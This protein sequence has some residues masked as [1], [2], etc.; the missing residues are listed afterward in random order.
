MRRTFSLWPFAVVALLAVFAAG[1]DSV[2]G[3]LDENVTYVIESYQEVGEFIGNVR[4]SRTGAINEL[5]SAS[6]VAVSGAAVQIHLMSESGGIES[7]FSLIESPTDPGVYQ[8]SSNHRILPLRVYRLDVQLPESAGTMSTQ[9]L[10]PGDFEIVR[11]GLKEV[12]YQ[13]QPQFEIGVTRSIYP[14]RQTVFV[15]SVEGLDAHISTLTPFYNDVIE[16]DDDG[17][18]DE[19]D[20][21][22]IVQS[23]PIN[24]ENYDVEPDGTLTLALPWLAVAFYGPNRVSVSAIDDN[25]YD[26]LRSYGIQQGGSTLSPGEIPNAIDHV[27]GGIGVFGSFARVSSETNILER[28]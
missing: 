28:Q 2:E 17:D 1:C 14:T 25:L 12:T 4:L 26:F 9:T 6:D 27:D 16:P 11:E 24:E 15:F 20:D 7:S 21:Y 23:P 8:S 3:V 5:N 22:R 10:T 19:L 13:R 18:E